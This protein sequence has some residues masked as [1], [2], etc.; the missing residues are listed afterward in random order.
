MADIAR[1]KQN[2]IVTLSEHWDY[3]P[4]S[5]SNCKKYAGNKSSD[6]QKDL[7]RAGVHEAQD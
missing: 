6:L 7:M 5:I 2:R 3:T 4:A 1:R